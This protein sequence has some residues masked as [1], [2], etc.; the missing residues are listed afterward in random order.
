MITFSPIIDRF[1]LTKQIVLIIKEFQEKPFLL[2]RCENR[3]EHK[4]KQTHAYYTTSV[5]MPLF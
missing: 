4:H 2:L 3:L 5:R 1:C